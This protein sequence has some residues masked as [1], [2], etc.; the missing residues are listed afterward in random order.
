MSF[1]ADVPESRRSSIWGASLHNYKRMPEKR[2][3]LKRLKEREDW[4]K[5]YSPLSSASL[6]QDDLNSTTSSAKV[7]THKM[8]NVDALDPNSDRTY[9]WLAIVSLTVTYYLWFIIVRMAFEGTQSTITLKLSWLALDLICNC[10]YGIDIYVQSH[11]GYLRNGILETSPEKMNRHYQS[12]WTF[13]IDMISII[14]FDILLDLGLHNHSVL[15][16]T[17][18]LKVYRL[19]EFT[20]LTENR[21]HYPNGYRVI[22]LLHNLLLIIHWNACVYYLIS[23]TIGF[24]SD[25]WVYPLQ[26]DTAIYNY[27]FLDSAHSYIYCF[28]WSTITLTT[29]GGHPEPVIIIEYL[30][31]IID[32]LVGILMFATLVGNIGGIIANIQKGKAK[33]QGRLD[34]VKSYMKAMAV[35]NHLQE[36]VIKWFDYLWTHGHPVNNQTALNTLP[37]KLKAEIAI[38]VHFETLKKVDFF[39]HCDQSFLWELVL[40][41]QIQVYSPGEY[42]CRKGDVGREMYIVSHGKL[43][44]VEE[45]DGDVLCTLTHGDYFGEISVL[46]LGRSHRR[47]TAFVR[48]VGYSDLLCLSQNDLFDVLYDYPQAMDILQKKGREKL[49]SAHESDEDF[50]E[51]AS[52]S[53]ENFGSQED[54]DDFVNMPVSQADIK[55]VT[56]QLQDLQIKIHDLEN[57]LKELVGEVKKGMRSPAG[58]THSNNEVINLANKEVQSTTTLDPTCSKPLRK[59]SSAF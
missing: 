39:D 31:M 55:H 33:F 58:L 30:F 16:W 41:I 17:K 51:F 50:S 52:Y 20:N 2:T 44:V 25:Q 15:V 42:V 53:D 32:Y 49:G 29:I 36:R 48:S 13:F 11:T 45:E 9:Q 23:K 57:V 5:K 35:P 47:R 6:L 18:L 1:L 34:R 14:P 28:Y 19:R 8:S 56:D 43:E 38:H 21:T 24:S 22:F 10:V 4:L 54:I 37:D 46:N 59:L 27:P 12:T 40:R 26:N 7:Q 3:S